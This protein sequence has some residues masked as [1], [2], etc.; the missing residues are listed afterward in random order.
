MNTPKADPATQSAP[1]QAPILFY[2][3]ACGLCTRSVKFFLR[4]DRRKRI[5]YA[6][7]QGE[8]AQMLLPEELRQPSSLSTV[9]Y[10]RAAPGPSHFETRSYAISAA[11]IDVGGCWGMMGKLLQMI[12]PCLRE[13]G[14]RFVASHRLQLFPKGA[15]ALP[16]QDERARLLP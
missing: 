1:T 8:T 4:I 5:C 11:L 9:V 15:C 16:T 3:G 6:P 12:P 13:A 10:R 7:L 2:D 14:Y